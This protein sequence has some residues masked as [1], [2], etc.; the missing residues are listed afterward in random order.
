MR[1]HWTDCRLVPCTLYSDKMRLA[2]LEDHLT[3]HS[4]RD[5]PHTMCVVCTRILEGK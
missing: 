3:K 1:V 2:L 4:L 5:Q